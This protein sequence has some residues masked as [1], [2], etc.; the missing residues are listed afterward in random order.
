MSPHLDDLDDVPP[1][2]SADELV[3]RWQQ[4]RRRLLGSSNLTIGTSD[5]TTWRFDGR[6]LTPLQRQ[7][8]DTEV[9]ANA[10][11]LQAEHEAAMALLRDLVA[12]H[13]A[14]ARRSDQVTI[15]A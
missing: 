5:L 7:L 15:G 11:A 10:A 2:P 6:P 8:L 4:R 9:P 1:T 3:E 14:V 12:V 13:E